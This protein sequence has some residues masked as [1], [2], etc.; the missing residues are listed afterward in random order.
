MHYVHNMYVGK[1]VYIKYYVHTPA[2]Y[3]R[4]YK[5][6]FKGLNGFK[7]IPLYLYNIYVCS[8]VHT[9]ILHYMWVNSCE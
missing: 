6:E 1:S 7:F 2:I 4:I 8:Y 9:I 3:I 5:M